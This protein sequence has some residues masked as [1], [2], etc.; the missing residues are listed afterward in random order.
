MIPSGG[1]RIGSNVSRAKIRRAGRSV[2]VTRIATP[3]PATTD[4]TVVSAAYC[5][6][7][8]AACQKAGSPSSWRYGCTVKT[9]PAS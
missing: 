5:R 4:I 8:S 6:V 1:S 7:L 2:R 9:P 3:A